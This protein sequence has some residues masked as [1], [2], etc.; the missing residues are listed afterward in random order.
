VGPTIIARD[1]AHE[2]SGATDHFVEVLDDQVVNLL[3]T[4]KRF[5]YPVQLVSDVNRTIRMS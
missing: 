3:C 2:L 1:L 4:Q 5:G